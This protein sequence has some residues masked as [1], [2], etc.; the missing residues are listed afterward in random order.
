M[1]D[2]IKVLVVGAGPMAQA[3]SAVLKHLDITTVYICRSEK[4]AQAFFDKTGILP[5]TGGLENWIQNNLLDESWKVIIATPVENLYQN[6]IDLLRAG[7]KHILVEKPGFLT[8]KDGA[9]V[10]ALA[11]SKHANVLI[12]YNRRFYSSVLAAEKIIEE[13]GGL[14]SLQYEFTEWSHVIAPL[15]KG[16]L[17]KERWFISN[18]THVVDLAF[19]L[20]GVP[21]KY[22]FLTSGG[23]EWH[24]S[25][26]VFAG[27]GNTDKNVLFSYASNWE[28]PGRWALELMTSKHRL[29]L[30]PMEKLQIQNI[31]SVLVNPVEIDERLD[32]EYKPGLYL[33]TEA[34][35]K[36]E[37]QRFT[38]AEDQLGKLDLY[39]EMANY[40]D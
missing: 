10:V 2:N 26:T 3:Y 22:H 29:Y 5:E 17:V 23:N 15:Q 27:S 25:A 30:K 11:K 18:S 20:G 21:V 1:P 34:Y 33:M 31:G 38:D 28:S 9:E 39:Y 16:P 19:F 32:V 12:A 37:H 7:A 4:S 14:T 36:G 35:I 6:T 40:Q 8:K 13:D 24:P